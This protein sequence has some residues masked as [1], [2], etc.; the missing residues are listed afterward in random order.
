MQMK[1]PNWKLILAA[2][3]QKDNKLKFSDNSMMNIYGINYAEK[4]KIKKNWTV[5][6]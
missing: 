4:T 3:L 5:L 1:E 6:T 2:S